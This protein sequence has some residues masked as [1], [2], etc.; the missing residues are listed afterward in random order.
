MA[1]APVPAPPDVPG[2]D[3]APGA[4][5]LA[6]CEQRSNKKEGNGNDAQ[7]GGQGL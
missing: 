2:P 7:C 6:G 3:L 1:L 4:N 5:P